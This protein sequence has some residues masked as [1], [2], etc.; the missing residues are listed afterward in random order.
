M[1][2]VVYKKTTELLP[3]ESVNRGASALR[4][5]QEILRA[6]PEWYKLHWCLRFEQNLGGHDR[7]H[8]T[9]IDHSKI[10]TCNVAAGV[11][12]VV[13]ILLLALVW[14]ETL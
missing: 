2:R 5:T 6:H 14:K 7:F 13:L 3:N 1:A 4:I 8:V 9:I 11:T 12:T 10:S